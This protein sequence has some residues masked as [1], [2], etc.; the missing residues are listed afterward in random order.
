MSVPAASFERWT[1]SL[2]ARIEREPWALRNAE[3]QTRTMRYRR[4]LAHLG[5]GTW[6]GLW[7][8]RIAAGAAEP[9]SEWAP[10][11]RTMRRLRQAA[12]AGT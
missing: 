4:L 2:L 5:V 8:P 10:I 6:L 7:S 9:F 3:H 12:F 11:W 1:L